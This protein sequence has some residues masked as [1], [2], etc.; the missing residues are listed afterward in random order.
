[1]AAITIF[2]KPN[3][4]QCTQT[5]KTFERGGLEADRDF[6]YRDV[7]EDPAAYAYVTEELGYSAAPVIVL[8]D[9]DHWSGYN[10]PNNKRAIAWA[11]TQR[12]Q[13]ADLTAEPTA[14]NELALT[15]AGPD[16][17]Q[18]TTA[19]TASSDHPGPTP[20]PPAPLDLRSR[21]VTSPQATNDLDGRVNAVVTSL[22]A[23]STNPTPQYQPYQ[24][25]AA[26]GH[27]SL[28]QL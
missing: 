10:P 4:V 17:E 25:A 20:D 23:A 22:N 28:S 5:V 12:E 24:A 9:Q 11:L 13:A 27:P 3:C 2:G 8:E 6:I 19:I 1:M 21:L 18:P 14:T 26:S 7:S 15:T 16:R